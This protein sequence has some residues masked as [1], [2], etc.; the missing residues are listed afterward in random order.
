MTSSSAY[1]AFLL[2]TVVWS[3][4]ITTL[5]AKSLHD[6]DDNLSTHS[7]VPWRSADNRTSLPSIWEIHYLQSYR[8]QHDRVSMYLVRIVEPRKN[9]S[10]FLIPE[11]LEVMFQNFAATANHNY[12]ATKEYKFIFVGE[13]NWNEN[14]MQ[15][16]K[17]IKGTC[18]LQYN[19]NILI[20]KHF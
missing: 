2:L 5:L 13:I 1:S 4:S 3:I 19:G 8:N 15:I 16:G 10:T 18:L 14:P 12:N 7:M 11:K 6:R 9:I 17:K 20:L